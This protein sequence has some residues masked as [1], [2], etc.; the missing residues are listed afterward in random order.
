MLAAA[1]IVG[2][3]AVERNVDPVMGSEDFSFML[4]ECPGAYMFLGVG[5]SEPLHHPEYDFND[6]VIPYGVSYR[7]DVPATAA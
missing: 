2:S 7:I 1:Q 6:D 4:Q 5:D 3:E